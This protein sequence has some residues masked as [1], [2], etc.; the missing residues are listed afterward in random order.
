MSDFQYVHRVVQPSP[1]SRQFEIYPSPQKETLYPF[2]VTP[3][4]PPCYLTSKHR[5]PPIYFLSLW[6][7]LGWV[8]HINGIVQYMVFCDWLL[9]LS[10]FLM[11]MHFVACIVVIFIDCPIFG[12]LESLHDGPCVILTQPEASLIAFCYLVWQFVQTCT[13]SA[14]VKEIDLSLRSLLV[15]NDIWRSQSGHLR[16]LFLL[17]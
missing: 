15:G 6:I 10:M 16:C 1:R 11:L 5:Q 14:P 2:A 9:L 3:H 17:S 8:F 13:F 7:C 12:Q 4:Y